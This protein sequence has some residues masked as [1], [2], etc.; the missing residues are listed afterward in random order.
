VGGGAMATG[1]RSG[2]GG[3]VGPVAGV[4][5]GPGQS[6]REVGLT[7]AWWPDEQDVGRRFQVAAGAQLVDELAVDPGGGV[8]VEVGQGGRGGQA[9]EPQPAGQ[10]AGGGGLDFHGQQPLQRHGQRQSLGGSLVEHRG[11]R[12]GGR[13]EFEFG[14]V[15]TQLLIATRRRRRRLLDGGRG[16][17][18]GGAGGGGHWRVLF[19]A[20]R[21]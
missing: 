11:Q 17:G 12:F 7:G 18:F 19:W 3:E 14:Q 4:R 2:G 9:G 20:A 5:G 6:H 10:P 21:S 1:G 16:G 13:G 15:R 8:D